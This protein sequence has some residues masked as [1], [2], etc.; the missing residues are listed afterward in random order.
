MLAALGGRRDGGSR[1][2]GSVANNDRHRRRI[3]ARE[4]AVACEA[5][6]PSLL[7]PVAGARGLIGEA[8]ARTKRA[9][10]VLR[11][12]RRTSELEVLFNYR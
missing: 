7:V 8:T 1:D 9:C 10:S 11:L 3:P 5:V 4:R 12:F 6:S 2:R